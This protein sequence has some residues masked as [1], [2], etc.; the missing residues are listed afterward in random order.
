M[1]LDSPQSCCRI[2]CH[3]SYRN[4]RD[5]LLLF[6]Y[7]NV[8]HG[9]NL[10]HLHRWRYRRLQCL[11]QSV[12]KIYNVFKQRKCNTPFLHRQFIT[13]SSYDVS[14]SFWIHFFTHLKNINWNFGLL[15][16][17][18]IIMQK[19][20]NTELASSSAF[21]FSDAIFVEAICILSFC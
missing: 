5:L 10:H 16:Y 20:I 7:E 1:K 11:D 3:R 4:V 19:K 12:S 14:T 21:L 17:K 6:L 13:N 18:S 9:E 2:R 15:L 8:W